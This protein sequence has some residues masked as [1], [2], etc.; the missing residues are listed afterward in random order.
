MYICGV[1]NLKK[2]YE[3]GISPKVYDALDLTNDW[4]EGSFRNNQ[5]TLRTRNYFLG[6]IYVAKKLISGKRVKSGVER[7]LR[8]EIEKGIETLFR[9][10]QTQFGADLASFKSGAKYQ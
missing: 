3:S 2:F 5:K 7:Q 8:I 9:N 6:S 10:S 4:W 1:I